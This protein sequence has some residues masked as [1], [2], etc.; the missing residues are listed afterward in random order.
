MEITDGKPAVNVFAPGHW[1]FYDSY[2]LIACQLARQLDRGGYRVN[3]FGLGD[4]D[5]PS[6]PDDIHAITAQP[7]QPSLGGIA[8][9]YPT[10]VYRHGVFAMHGPRVIVTMFES[11]RI[12][13]AWVEPLN[14]YDAVVVPSM[15]CKW[16]FEA[17]GVSAPI[18]VI[19]LGI[20]DQYRYVERPDG[21]PLTFLAFMDRGRR[22]GGFASIQAFLDAFGE[23][24]DYRLILKTRAGGRTVNFTNPNIDIIQADLSEF[25]LLDLYASAD[26]LIN[27]NL[28]E[29]FGLIPREFAAT[30]G[31]SL[32]TAWGGTAEAINIWGVPIAY[33]L[34]KADWA[35]HKNLAGQ[36]L[37]NWAIPRHADIVEKIRDIA[38]HRDAYRAHAQRAASL[39]PSM[40]SWRQFG[41]RMIELWRSISGDS[42]ANHTVARGR[43]R[44]RIIVA[45]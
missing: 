43:R 31:I 15:F 17:S 9:G 33:D 40:Y 14:G 10:N 3:A 42:G 22:K 44:D 34:A 20:G 5:H 21:R 39:L 26:V 4:R 1:D 18:H 36:P 8:L 38:E 41:R 19:P 23:S 35:G 13:P 6:L 2:G 25:E 27:P 32:A 16:V 29:G 28:G 12:P 11:S 24:M 37:G 7:I 45:D 30:G